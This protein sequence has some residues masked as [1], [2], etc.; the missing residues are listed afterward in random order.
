MSTRSFRSLS[1]EPAA[2][3]FIVDTL[4]WVHEAGKPFFDCF[5]GGIDKARSVLNDW[6][7]RPSSE[8]SIQ[9]VM[10]FTVADQPIGGF[11]ALRGAEL[12][13][14]RKADALAAMRTAGRERWVLLLDRMKAARELFSPVRIDEFYLS[15]M[16]IV[17]DSRGAGHGAEIVREYLAMGTSQGFRRFRLDVWSENHTALRLYRSFGFQMLRE[18]SSELAG[19]KYINMVLIK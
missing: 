4:P 8:V 16:G 13:S 12:E 2:E 7:R 5:F 15:K 10:L 1:D 14:C 9:R 19:M 17:A 18:P 6:M 11:I 3:R